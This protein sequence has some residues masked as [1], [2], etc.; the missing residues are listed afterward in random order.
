[1]SEDLITGE[2]TSH[3]QSAVE[4]TWWWD[5]ATPGL[6]TDQSGSLRNTRA[7]RTPLKH[8]RSLKSASVVP[9]SS[10]TGVKESLG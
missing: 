9:Q 5:K 2:E 10:M 1:M 4:P 6:V 8:S 3:E 7:P